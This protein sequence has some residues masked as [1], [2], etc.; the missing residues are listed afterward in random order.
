M[1]S[2]DEKTTPVGG[3]Q[4]SLFWRYWTAST[5]SS[6]GDAVTAMAL[7][8][9]AVQVLHA[10]TFEISL[11]TAASFIA[12]IVIG[13]PA[14]VIV[15]R[16]PLRGT[17]IAMDVARAAA[18]LS[19][20]L[21]H[22][23]GILTLAQ[24]VAVALVISFAGVI[25]DVGNSTFLPA[26]V[27][28]EE[29]TSRN[30]LTSGS[31]AVTQVAGPSLGG[32]L[33]QL[34][35]AVTSLVVD[36]ISY[37]ASAVLLASLPRPQAAAPVTRNASAGRMIR[38]GWRYVVHH[39]VVRPCVAAATTINFV[40][41]GLMALTPV[42]LVRTLGAP[43]G[44]VGLLFAAEGVGSLI[45]AAVTTRLSKVLGSSPAIRWATLVGA[46]FALLLP[47]AT[48]KWGLVLFAVGNI[49]FAIGIVVLSILTRTHR[50]ATTPPE[51]L[52]RVMATVR[53]I[54]WGA[55]PVG[56]VTAGVLA[57]SFGNREALWVIVGAAFLTPAVLWGSSLRGKRDLA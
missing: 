19:I 3:R 13:L 32:I 22:L 34:L 52:A 33:V 11:I 51:L 40:A 46:C 49:G 31:Q 21:A 17:Q 28:K 57:T 20:P 15:H 29:L 27:T 4:S 44:V 42:F 10:S 54:S 16:F 53:F 24:V 43:V 1:T 38:D 39:E 7:P 56:A 14:G 5:V 2:T 8:L 26:I 45:G 35:G 23:A 12:W 9:V 41:G 25:F 6:A 36:V 48:A 18:L 30:S 47:L 55:V 37:L 50:Q